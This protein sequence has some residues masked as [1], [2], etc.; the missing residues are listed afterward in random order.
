M[1]AAAGKGALLALL[2]LLPILP[3]AA[4]QAFV[5][6]ARTVAVERSRGVDARVDYAALLALG[7]WDDRNYELTLED[8][9]VLS[10]TER[11]QHVAIP[12]FYRVRLRQALPDLPRTGEAQ[13]PRH[14][15]HRFRDAYGGYLVNGRLYREVTW[16]GSHFEVVLKDGIAEESFAPGTDALAG[17]VRL[18]SPTGA[19]ESAIKFHPTDPSKVIAGTNGPGSGQ[20]MWWSTDGG[21]SWTRVFLPLGNTAGD[22]SVDW[23]ANGAFAYTTTLASCFSIGCQ[24]YFYRSADGGKT[25]NSLETATPGDPRREF[26]NNVDKE[27][28]HVDKAAASPFRGRIYVAWHENNVQKWA[29]SADQGNT[30]TTGTF[31]GASEELGIGSDITSG[32]NGHAYYIWPGV[33][34]RTIRMRKSTDGGVTWSAASTV[35]S[36][37]QG[38]YDFPLPSMESRRTFI[39]VSADADTGSGPF[40]GSIYAA[41]TDNVNADSPTPSQNHG[42]I[43]VARSRDGGATWQVTTPHETAD[44]LTVD[45]YHPWLAVGQNG[46]VHVIFYDTRRDPTRNSVDIFYASSSDGAATWSAPQ[47]LTSVASVNIGDGFEWGD[48]NGLDVIGN[49]LI[50]IFTDNRNETGGTTDSVDVYGAAAPAAGGAGAVPDGRTIAGSPLLATRVGGDIA[51]DWSTACGAATDYATYEGE[52]GNPASALPKACSSGGATQLTLTPAAGSRFYLVVPLSGGREGSYGRTSDGTE[53]APSAS[54]CAPQ[55]LAGC[56]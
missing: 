31:P 2:L 48:Y 56:P 9:S 23:S 40:A 42:R 49:N 39:Y 29:R 1:T 10:P 45:R 43:Q 32:P 46:T 44:Q 6:R 12:A 11:E 55:Q 50:A 36:P 26:G 19:S 27:Y 34:S 17:E 16:S 15:L 38:S 3:A 47:R 37:T 35:V 41:W 25:W 52:L 18:T 13:Y 7:P 14:T 8:L 30:F 4:Q 21:S 54:P 28:L 5:D 24:V 53:R 20:G 22:P 33:N 51:L